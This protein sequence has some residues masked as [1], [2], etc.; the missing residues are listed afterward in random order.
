MY[1]LAIIVGYLLGSIPF[2]FLIARVKG[3]DIRKVGSGNIGFTNVL[4]TCGVVPGVLTCILDVLKGFL[5][6][7]IF[8]HVGASAQLCGILAGASAMLGHIFSAWL[9]FKGGKGVATG[10]GVFLALA[11]QAILIAAASWGIAIAITRIVSVGS[12]TSGVV[13]PVASFILYGNT[14][15]SYFA[16]FAGLISIFKHKQNIK[17]LIAGKEPRLGRRK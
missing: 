9:K 15:V 4:R 3:I 8:S 12:I 10:L 13:L 1:I 16:L 17:R 14:P 2:G 7:Y 6:T 5:P 11:P